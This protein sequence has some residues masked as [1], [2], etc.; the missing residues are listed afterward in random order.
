MRCIL[1]LTDLYLGG[2]EVLAKHCLSWT[3]RAESE[4]HD[5]EYDFTSQLEGDQ[6]Y[7]VVIGVSDR[8]SKNYGQKLEI[9]SIKITGL[10]PISP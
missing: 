8:W 5:F 4:W 10:T 1:L 6:F 7:R 3:D 2:H 9:D